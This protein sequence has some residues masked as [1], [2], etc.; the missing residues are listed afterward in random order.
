MT[1]VYCVFLETDCGTASSAE[2]PTL[3]K[4]FAKKMSKHEISP[5]INTLLTMTNSKLNWEIRT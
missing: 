1:C 2:Q 4:K 5:P 3:F